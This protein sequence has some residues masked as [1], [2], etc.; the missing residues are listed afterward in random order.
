MAGDFTKM[1]VK[2]KDKN[3][4]FKITEDEL[5]ELRKSK[6]VNTTMN[7]SG[8]N[9]V[10]TINPQGKFTEM[11]SRLAIDQDDAYLILSVSL[12]KLEELAGMGRSREGLQQEIGGVV[13]SLQVDVRKVNR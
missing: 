2:I 6:H 5:A 1:N 8:K 12:E 4:C 3:L 7:L 10:V 9:F 11:T 13:T